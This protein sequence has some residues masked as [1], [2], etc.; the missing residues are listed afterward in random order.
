MKQ[1]VAHKPPS[2]RAVP[3]AR[4]RQDMNWRLFL[5]ACWLAV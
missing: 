4:A 3:A 2:T 1:P 5:V